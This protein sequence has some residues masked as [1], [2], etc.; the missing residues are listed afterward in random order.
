M[1]DELH[2]QDV[3]LIREASII[4]ARGLTVLTGET[5]TGKSALLSSVKLLMGERADASAVREGADALCVEGR[6]FE[7]G[8]DPDGTVVR[9]RVEAAGR[10]RVEVD[11][12]MASVRELAEGPGAT[13]DLCGQHEHQRLLQ[14]STHV[15][16][17]DA[18]V[19]DAAQEA[20]K[21]YRNA[22]DA[23]RDA[24]SELERK[25][26]MS[27]SA[28]ER[29]EEAEFVLRR[30]DEVGPAEGE[31]EELEQT[32]PKAEHAESLMRSATEAREAMSG[33]GGAEDVLSSVVS[34]L[35]GAARNDER[36]GAL[37]DRVESSLIDL[38]DVSA[39]LRD[40]AEAMDFD[41]DRL[42]Q[43][44]ERMGELQG[45]LRSYGPRM[46]DVLERRAKAAELMSA[47]H[48]GDAVVRAAQEALDAAEAELRARADE[49]DA[50]RR[51]AAPKL[52]AAIT[53]QMAFLQMGSA[54]LELGFERLDR[55]QWTSAGP[56]R[57]E[58]TYRPAAGLSARP[59]RRIASGGEV[60]RVML[61]CKVVLGDADGTDTLVFDEVDA[62]VGGATAVAL[63]QVLAR[64][65][66]THQV[67]VV[68]HLA[69]VAVVA[70]KHYLVSKRGDEVPET[71]IEE[72]GG[73]ERVAE[74]ARMLSGD[75][76]QASLDHA[77]E[78]LSGASPT[79]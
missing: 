62:G 11:G 15:Q 28:G 16:M 68:T 69:Q 33:D 79:S 2:V 22:L 72:I 5:G 56:S 27:R 38:E 66:Q 45:L 26:E 13:I 71:T 57:V 43:M 59:L 34:D 53:D 74:I 39:E 51:E 65:A 67:I 1:I 78:M 55:A 42:A 50:V 58:M 7:P 19:G 17:L 32:L 41:G 73:E 48:D 10:G 4:P 35:R 47:A 40:Y 44:Q 20:L 75:Q 8:G 30:I 18:W 49:L 12:H 23:A 29:L 70:Q 46:Q 63:A 3:A 9:R 31:Y 25:V 24:Q 76:T 36:L 21:A 52:A 77:R 61:A 64:L 6:F 54:S 60:S 14:G 37:A